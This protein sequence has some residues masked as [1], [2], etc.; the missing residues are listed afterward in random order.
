[1]CNTCLI[2]RLTYTLHTLSHRLAAEWRMNDADV[3]MT[4]FDEMFCAFVTALLVIA[5]H[6]VDAQF[7]DVAVNEHHRHVLFQQVSNAVAAV[8][9]GHED[10]AVDALAQHHFDVGDFFALAFLSTAYQRAV[11]AGE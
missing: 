1:M 6:T 5:Q 10:Y 3:L 4:Q 11:I 2:Q 7:G 8:A 9:G